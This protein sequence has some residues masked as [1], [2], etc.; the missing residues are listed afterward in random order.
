MHPEALESLME[1][2]LFL[3]ERE[4]QTTSI[5][6]RPL[7]VKMERLHGDLSYHLKNLQKE[8]GL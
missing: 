2:V 8:E 1:T 3:L 4:Q 7:H 5:A 6:Y